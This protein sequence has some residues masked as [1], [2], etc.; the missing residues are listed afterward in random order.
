MKRSMVVVAAVAAALMSVVAFPA[1]AQ[2]ANGLGNENQSGDVSATFSVSSAGSN[3]SQCAAPL[4]FGN[5]GSEQNAQGFLQYASEADDLGGESGTLGFA[6]SLS[7]GCGTP[8]QQSS[9]ANGR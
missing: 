4:Q 2:V 1:V 5:T 6:P 7:A 9:A 8:V 3:G